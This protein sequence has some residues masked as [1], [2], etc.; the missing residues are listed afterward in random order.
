[1]DRHRLVNQSL[2]IF[3]QRLFYKQLSQSKKVTTEM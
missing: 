2:I 1:M 3:K